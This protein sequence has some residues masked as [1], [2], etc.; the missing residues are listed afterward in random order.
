MTDESDSKFLEKVFPLLELISQNKFLPLLK[1]ALWNKE[2]PR[3]LPPRPCW[4]N[5]GRGLPRKGCWK[6]EEAFGGVECFW[7][8]PVN[9]FFDF[10]LADVIFASF[11]PNLS[12]NKYSFSFASK[13]RACSFN[14]SFTLVA[15]G[16]NVE[17]IFMR[18]W[19]ANELYV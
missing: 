11:S 16:I 13:S 3:P 14:I 9:I 18:R 1:A 15:L 12:P 7:W 19:Y 6:L 17:S 8:S 2:P 5:C 10:C 4:L